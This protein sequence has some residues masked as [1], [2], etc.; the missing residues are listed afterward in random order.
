MTRDK[1]VN[2]R[3][4]IE[5]SVPIEEITLVAVSADAG[6]S[7]YRFA[8]PAYQ[9]QVLLG[10]WDEVKHLFEI[11]IEIGYGGV[12]GRAFHIWTPT[13]VYFMGCYDGAQWVT[14]VPRHPTSEDQPVAIGGG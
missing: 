8:D 5:Q 6:G 9:T 1:V 4:W 14:W 10:K 3:E 11:E 13:K 2:M 7:T 12:E